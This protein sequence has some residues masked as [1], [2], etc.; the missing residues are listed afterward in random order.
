MAT[1][2]DVG[3]TDA[4]RASLSLRTAPDGTVRIVASAPG[5][6]DIFYTLTPIQARVLGDALLRRSADALA[7]QEITGAVPES[8]PVRLDWPDEEDRP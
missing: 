6:Y 5:S 8:D 4:N 3:T 1:I 2:I 7:L